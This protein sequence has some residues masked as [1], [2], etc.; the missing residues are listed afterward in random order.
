[1]VRIYAILAITIGGTIWFYHFRASARLS[2]W[3][4]VPL[5]LIAILVIGAS[6]H[7]LAGATHEATH[8]TLFKNRYLN[9]LVSD[10]FCMFPL[11]SSTYQFRLHHLAHHQ[12]I[13]DPVRD[14][15]FSQLKMSGHWLE[16][17]ASKW[18]FCALLLKQL[19][20]PNLL[21]YVWAR[22]RYDSVGHGDNP[23]TSG[24]DKPSQLLFVAAVAYSVVLCVVL[25]LCMNHDE[26]ML[27]CVTPFGFLIAAA[28]FVWSLPKR[29]FVRSRLKP[30]I[31]LRTTA[32]LR[33]LFLT[34]LFTAFGA[35]TYWTGVWIG[36]YFLLLWIV[37]LL[38][39]FGFFMLLRQLIQHGNGGRGWLNNTR[40]FFVNPLIR[41]AV[42][43]FGMDY[44]L[45]HHMYATVPHYR[46]PALHE[47]LLKY[48]DYAAQGLVVENY[49]IPKHRDPPRN[50]TVLEVIGPD[51]AVP[52]SHE[53]FIDETVLDG[54]DVEERDQ[55]SRHGLISRGEAQTMNAVGKNA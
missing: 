49:F 16:F 10:W 8:H 50:P 21:K 6:Q 1:M 52:D 5:T 42:F 39:S 34:L 19:W 14:P 18:R 17:P 33:V 43:P 54:W 31:P 4:N 9:E 41:Y 25:R 48:P 20:L 53:V 30:V 45:P 46:L 38:T 22:A 51:Y 32:F 55:I 7:Q 12:F 11:F 28:A 37:P 23:Y 44:H 15:D 47:F 29:S 40:V 2:V 36:K 24:V 3:W 27:F 13:N 26:L 35:M